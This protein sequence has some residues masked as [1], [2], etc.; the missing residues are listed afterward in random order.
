MTNTTAP[1]GNI[2][3]AKEYLISHTKPEY[4]RYIAHTLAG[5]FALALACDLHKQRQALTTISQL[6]SSQEDEAA[7]IAVL[8]LAK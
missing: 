4:Q 5:D 3:Q 2:E 6:P 8:A 1:F 7:I